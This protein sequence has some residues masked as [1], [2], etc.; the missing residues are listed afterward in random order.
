MTCTNDQILD[1]QRY[2]LAGD[3]LA[4]EL[5]NDRSLRFEFKADPIATLADYGAPT[6]RLSRARKAELHRALSENVSFTSA[7]CY[8]C[9]IGLNA[10]VLA[11]GGGGAV[12]AAAALPESATAEAFVAAVVELTGLSTTAVSAIVASVGAAA[13]GSVATAIEMF[14]SD[15]CKKMGAC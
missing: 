9:E 1:L 10:A 2:V 11:L 12:L 8:G 7:K 13:G 4:A 3:Y 14:I 15:L 5:P 6:E